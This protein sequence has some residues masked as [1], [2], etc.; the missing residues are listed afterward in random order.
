M[1]GAGAAGGGAAGMLGAPQWL[2]YMGP[3][4]NFAYD[5]ATFPETDSVTLGAAPGGLYLIGSRPNWSWDGKYLA[6]FAADALKVREMTT[7]TPGP[8]VTLA[9]ALSPVDHAG[10]LQWSWDSKS[11]SVI[12]GTSLFVVD[13]TSATPTLNVVTSNNARRLQWAPAG[14][15]LIYSEDGGGM[16]YVR[17]TA[18]VPGAPE[19]VA[20]IGQSWGWSRDGSKLVVADDFDVSLF[21][22]SGASV[23]RTPLY[24]I[25]ALS[26]YANPVFDSSGSLVTFNTD[27]GITYVATDAPAT[28]GVI[29]S[30]VS[31]T[32]SQNPNWSLTDPVMVFT[33]VTPPVTTTNQWFYVKF[34]GSTPSEPTPIPGTWQYHFW[35]P[36]ELAMIATDF[37]SGQASRI[38]LSGATPVVTPYPTLPEAVSSVQWAPIGDRLAFYTRAAVILASRSDPSAPTQRIDSVQSD[39]VAWTGWSSAASHLAIQSSARTYQDNGI[40][41]VRVDGATPS[42]VMPLYPLTPSTDVSFAWQPVTQ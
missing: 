8:E 33:A 20:M 9:T 19:R 34:T 12:S 5:A 40:E 35:I 42:A 38:D 23:Q 18:G 7:H 29:E 3:D 27:Q 26:T 15:G 10:A 2:A 36:G 14:G 32:I 17:I 4:G 21:D 30:P 41:I 6:Y 28:N 39:V 24:T 11:I 31:G 22:L 37:P 16:N 25:P 1:G 13:P